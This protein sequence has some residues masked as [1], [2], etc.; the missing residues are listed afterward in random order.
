MEKIYDLIIIGS[1]PAGLSAAIYAQRARLD[2]LIIEKDMTS[3]GQ[4]L[5]TYEVDNYPGLPGINGFDLGMK[6]REHADKLGACFVTDEVQKVELS[7]PEAGEYEEFGVSGQ[8]GEF[9]RA[10]E[11]EGN[12]DAVPQ[13]AGT[14]G[15]KDRLSVNRRT[16]GS[17]GE[18]T[19]KNVICGDGTY[20]S[21]TLL[22][23]TGARHRKLGVPGEEKLSGMGVS[24]CATCDGAFFRNREVAVVGG[25]DVALEDAIFLSRMCKKVYLIHRRDELR[26]AKSLQET[27]F[28]QENI[29]ILWDTQ[30]EEIQ[31]D[32]KV[33]S[34]SLINK[35]T[36]MKSVLEVQG[37]FIAVGITPNS[38]NFQGLVDMEQGYIRAGED[39]KTSVPGIFAAGDVRTKMLRQI[40]T[41]AA[42]G[43]NGVTA[44]ERYLAL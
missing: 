43:A 12:K 5:T 13:A 29:R 26:G 2:T 38:Q 18:M 23:A 27:V 17:L 19:I 24:Y 3:G 36:G 15:D 30:V 34:L 11:L 4:V 40:V 33:E 32:M 7:S 8:E 10:A 14:P 22:I 31:G 44:V 42:D 21:K 9:V 28:K 1:G 41:A 20:R 6:F 39:T 16:V 37:V 35:K 25:G